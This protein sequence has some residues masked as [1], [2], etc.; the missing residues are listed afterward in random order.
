MSVSV[1]GHSGGMES[2]GRLSVE[3]TVL[4]ASLAGLV[5][6][7][8]LLEG[9]GE[10]PESGSGQESADLQSPEKEHCETERDWSAL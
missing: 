7:Q 3:P 2:E 4:R 6:K 9:L 5:G 10:Q 8:A 1:L